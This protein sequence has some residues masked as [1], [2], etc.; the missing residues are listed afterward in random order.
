MHNTYAHTPTHT[1]PPSRPPPS[2]AALPAPTL[3]RLKC[4]PTLAYLGPGASNVNSPVSLGREL[5]QSND[6]ESTKALLKSFI[7]EC[8]AEGESKAASK[9][10][11]AFRKK[12]VLQA[13]MALL[14]VV[15]MMAGI[16]KLDVLQVH[17]HTHTHTQ[18]QRRF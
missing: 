8:V 9:A 18:A 11:R 15:F 1:H 12:L 16:T 2:S 7:V 3:S 4:I 6:P 13:N 14:G 10:S 5:E 17:T